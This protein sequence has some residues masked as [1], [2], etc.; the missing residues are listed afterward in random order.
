[1]MLTILMRERERGGGEGRGETDIER[2]SG[3]EDI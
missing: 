3:E 1:M 2:G